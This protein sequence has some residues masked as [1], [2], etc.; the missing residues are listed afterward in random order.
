VAT[1]TPDGWQWTCAWCFETA[2]DRAPTWDA[3]VDALMDA[4]T[5]ACRPYQ[6]WRQALEKGE[7]PRTKRRKRGPAHPKVRSREQLTLP[8]VLP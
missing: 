2:V 8:S 6:L 7:E 1:E 3:A 5:P 4:H